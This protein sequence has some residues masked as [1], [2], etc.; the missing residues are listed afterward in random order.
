MRKEWSKILM[1]LKSN[2]ISPILENSYGDYVFYGWN[3][4]IFSLPISTVTYEVMFPTRRNFA[5]TL[6][7]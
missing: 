7:P 3:R 5:K 2:K 6:R 4:V 1:I